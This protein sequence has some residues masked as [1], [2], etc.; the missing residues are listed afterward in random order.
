[1]GAYCFFPN[2]AVK[3]KN[4]FKVPDNTTGVKLTNLITVFL[5]GTEGSEI[6]YVINGVGNSV[7]RKTPD[8]QI[9]YVCNY[10]LTS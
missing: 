9:S 3:I 4:G 7:H 10:P 1:M 2:D 8:G 6:T 5:D